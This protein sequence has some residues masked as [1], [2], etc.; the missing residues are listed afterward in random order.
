MLLHGFWRVSSDVEMFTNIWSKCENIAKHLVTAQGMWW[1]E[2]NVYFVF[3]LR[4][5]FVSQINIIFIICIADL[6]A[7]CNP[8]VTSK[9][10]RTVKSFCNVSNFSL[11]WYL[12][13]R[14]NH[15][16]FYLV[17][18]WAIKK[19]LVLQSFNAQMFLIFF[20]TCWNLYILFYK[21]SKYYACVL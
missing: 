3:K 10:N 6:W 21:Y 17:L 1:R 11:L 7:V 20:Y 12:F 15:Y 19:Y 2:F 16:C 14:I 13:A 4:W 18:D 8:F 9:R 5:T